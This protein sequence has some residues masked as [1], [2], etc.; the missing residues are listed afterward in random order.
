MG[1]FESNYGKRDTTDESNDTR[2]NRRSAL[3][4]A[5]MKYAE[6]SVPALSGENAAQRHVGEREYAAT[7]RAEQ[8][9]EERGKLSTKL[10][11]VEG[12][13]QAVTASIERIVKQIQLLTQSKREDSTKAM[14]MEEA[15]KA[16]GELLAEKGDLEAAKADIEKRLAG[17][18]E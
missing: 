10:T 12:S 2:N 9:E 18:G 8:Q 4:Q 17:L 6:G 13:I 14:I 7:A 3:R 15:Q 1:G 11:E 16:K 5:D